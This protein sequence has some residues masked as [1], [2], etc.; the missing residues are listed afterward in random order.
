MRALEGLVPTI[1]EDE[2][3]CP[4]NAMKHPVGEGPDDLEAFGIGIQQDELVHGQP[5][6]AGHQSLD[7]LRR[8][9]ASPAGDGHLHTHGTASYT[10]AVKSLGKFPD[11]FSAEIAGQPEALRRAAAGLRDQLDTLRALSGLLTN[12]TVILTGMGGSYAACY[13][14][15][16]DLAEAG[17]T[18]VM[19]G[20]AE[21][22]HFRAGIL[23]PSSPVIAVSQS[24]ESAEIVHLAETLRLRE[25]GPSIVAVTNGANNTLARTADLVL[26]TR[27]GGEMGP[28]TGTFGAALVM[29]AGLGKVLG[30]VSPDAACEALSG[31]AERA[32]VSIERHLANPTLGDAVLAWLGPR[33][34]VVVLGRG[35]AR[36]AAEMA[37]L[38]LKEA[39]GLPAEALES[40]QFRH[41]PLEL[42][43]PNLAVIVIATEPETESL[44]RSL[45]RDLR[46]A[47]AAVLEI[48]RGGGPFGIG[49]IDRSIAPAV[50][51][52][53]IQLFAHR[54]AI[55]RGREP[56]MYVHAAKVTTRE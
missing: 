13:P 31:E 22:L 37:A 53:P 32:A 2:P 19:L 15:A 38:T 28:S 56:G 27:A 40:A 46:E 47:G 16:A 5:I 39:V 43:G 51:I 52:V 50:S 35:P 14:L 42:A 45:A 17:I 1:G 10:A 20:S 23:G 4:S 41:G 9:R 48:T 24:G 54:L 8:V 33:E 12:R 34:D 3:A 25:D 26:D 30:G 44:D 7:E 18:A 11:P 55:A 29:L 36:A 21:L 6:G 49:E